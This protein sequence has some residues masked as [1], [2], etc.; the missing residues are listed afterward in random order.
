MPDRTG[1]YLAVTHYPVGTGEMAKHVDPNYF[2][3]VHYNL[4][5]SFKGIDYQFGGL[6]IHKEDQVIDV[7][8]QMNP[9]DVLL[10]SGTLPHSVQKVG[11]AGAQSHIGRLQLFSIP[12]QFMKT[13]PKSLIREWAFDLYGRFKYS[14]YRRGH[15]FQQDHKNFR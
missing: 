5:L 1:V 14:Q 2:L 15:G 6:F 12:T 4:P 9:G 8:A 10:F 3:P 13:K 11:G 7:D